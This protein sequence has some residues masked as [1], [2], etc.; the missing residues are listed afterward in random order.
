M[1]LSGSCRG[2][3]KCW[4]RSHGAECGRALRTKV[5]MDGHRWTSVE[6]LGDLMRMAWASGLR[7]NV[8]DGV[9]DTTLDTGKWAQETDGCGDCWAPQHGCGPVGRDRTVVDR[10]VQ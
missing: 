1:C 7:T 4:L 2:G 3:P 5:D 10:L 6:S 9:L 8:N